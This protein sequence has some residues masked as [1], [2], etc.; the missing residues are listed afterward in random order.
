MKSTRKRTSLAT[1]HFDESSPKKRRM[2]AK[3]IFRSTKN[4]A[5][6]EEE[7]DVGY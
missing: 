4:S 7:G 5:T 1:P 3:Y 2:P 6:S